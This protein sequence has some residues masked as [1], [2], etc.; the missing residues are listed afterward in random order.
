MNEIIILDMLN[1]NSVSIRIQ[2]TTIVNGITYD[3]G[4]PSR[5]GYI[6]SPMGRQQLQ[7][8][9]VNQLSYLNAIM[10]VWGNSTTMSD[11]P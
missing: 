2:Q 9:L 7:L 5:T 10:A 1:P 6:N 4:L 11:N 3:V 8:A